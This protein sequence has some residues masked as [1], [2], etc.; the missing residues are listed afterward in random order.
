[1]PLY[2]C[3]LLDRT[4][5]EVQTR[6]AAANDAEAIKMAR[7]MG[8]NSG[9]HWLELWQKERCVLIEREPTSYS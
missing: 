7:N 9:A 6:V 4:R 1:M 8:A 5:T 3:R 2:Q